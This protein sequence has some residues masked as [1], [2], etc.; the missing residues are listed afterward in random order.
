MFIEQFAGRDGQ[1]AGFLKKNL[2]AVFLGFIGFYYCFLRVLLGF[3]DFSP[4]NYWILSGMAKSGF[5]KKTHW[6]GFFGFYWFFFGVL[7]ILGLQIT[8]FYWVLLGF[9]SF[10][11]KFWDVFDFCPFELFLI[12]ALFITRFYGVLW[13]FIRF[14]WVFSLFLNDFGAIF[15]KNQKNQSKNP[16]KHH[17]TW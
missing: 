3:I 4:S 11:N 5:L 12:L 1:K 8:G 16:P 10:L 14:Y 13:G 17:K 15:K 2:W 7:L 6:D 9:F